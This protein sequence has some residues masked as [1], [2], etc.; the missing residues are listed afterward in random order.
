M[1]YC[2]Y[3][4]AGLDADMRFCPKCGKP[5]EESKEN[6]HITGKRIKKSLRNTLNQHICFPSIM[7]RRRKNMAVLS[8][9]LLLLF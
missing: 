4:G 2:P 1:K 3:C 6:P 5:F 8:R 7:N 9:L